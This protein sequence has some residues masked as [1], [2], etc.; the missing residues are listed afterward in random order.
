MIPT[1]WHSEKG[2]TM[3]TVKISVVLRGWGGRGE[4]NKQST[5]DFFFLGQWKYSGWYHNGGYMS[6]HISPNQQNVQH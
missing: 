6:L 2:K 5:E 4:M 1:I 3:D